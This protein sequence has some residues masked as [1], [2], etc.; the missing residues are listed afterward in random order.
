[1]SQPPKKKSTKKKPAKKRGKGVIRTGRVTRLRP[2]KLFK[3][4]EVTALEDGFGVLLDGRRLKT[5]G[6][7]ELVVEVE[8]V[9]ELV[10]AEWRAQTG[11]IRP[12]EMPVMR[13]VSGALDLNA[14]DR[15]RITEELTGYAAS[16]LICYRAEEPEALQNAQADRWEPILA[17]VETALNAR[18]VRVAGIVYREQPEETVSAFSEAISP[19]DPIALAAFYEVARLTG[20]ALIA[21]AV[22]T[23]LTTWPDGWIAA[24]VDEDWQIAQW[25][26]DGEALARR[27]AAL[28][29][30]EAA[31]TVM[32]LC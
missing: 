26:E 18:F 31:C 10:A 25:G 14:D 23:G 11:K 19:I 29:D 7:L 17:G 9:A 24:H 16:D 4:V 21:Y 3:K 8:D 1:M 13:L 15:R 12:D 6:G 2:K 22:Y 32:A 28:K 20:S 27:A 5:P 30:Y